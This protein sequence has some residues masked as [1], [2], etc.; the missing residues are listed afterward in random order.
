MKSIAIDVRPYTKLKDLAKYKQTTITEMMRQEF[1]LFLETLKTKDFKKM[2]YSK[3]V[4]VDQP[5]Q[6]LTPV[7]S[8]KRSLYNLCLDL[9]ELDLDAPEN[10][11]AIQESLKQIGT[12]VENYVALNNFADAQIEMLKKEREHVD[13]QIASFERVRDGLEKRALACLKMLNTKEIKSETGHK[14]QMR[15]SVSVDVF[16]AQILPDWARTV[17]TT[18]APAKLKI[19]EAIKQGET[20]AGAQLVT[21]EYAVIK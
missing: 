12:K 7:V 11:V 18:V 1:P 8:E 3:K 2:K 20:V 19:K 14:I 10:E 9:V 4:E 6:E 5:A 15:E 17:T 21:K 16:N 13:R